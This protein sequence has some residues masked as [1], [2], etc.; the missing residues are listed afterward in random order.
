MLA[1]SVGTAPENA[2]EV[3]A[4]CQGELDRLGAEGITPREL[5]V[6]KGHLRAD[7]LL[8]LED[9]GARMSRIGAGLLLFDSVL[10]VEEL[11]GRIAGVTGDQV[12]AVAERVL[13][14]ARTLAVV[15]P[16]EAADFHDMSLAGT[17]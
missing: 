14:A 1:I 2:H 10:T 3:L 11:L 5:E 7:L 13:T 4:L 15:G 12:R 8:S 9:S 16:F 6:A 17:T